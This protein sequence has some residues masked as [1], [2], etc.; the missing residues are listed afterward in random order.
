MTC[1][2]VEGL[3]DHGHP[4]HGSNGAHFYRITF[5]S[6]RSSQL[7]GDYTLALDEEYVHSKPLAP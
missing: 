6:E 4:R 3:K 1:Y 7:Y 5:V 2:A